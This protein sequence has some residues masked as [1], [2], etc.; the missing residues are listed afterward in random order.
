MA[1][2][3]RL[4]RQRLGLCLP[5]RADRPLWLHAASVG[6]LIAALPLLDALR[7]RHP[8]VPLIVTTTT[9]TGAR[10]ARTRLPADIVH[11]YLPVDWP[12]AVARFLRAVQ[13]RAALIMETELWPHL[14]L[15]AAARAIPLLIVNGRLSARSLHAGAWVKQLFR[16][17][18]G[19][20]R[21]VL[22]RSQ[23]DAEGYIA[24]GMAA[25]R[26]RVLGNIKFAAPPARQQAAPI[27]LGRPYVLAA[28]THADEEAQI[29]RLWLAND[30]GARFSRLLVIA[31]RHPAR[32]DAILKQ[33]QGLPATVAV[34]SRGERAGAD[35][36]IYLADTLG[37]LESFL[38]A[39]DIVFMGG[40]LAARG[41]HNILEAARLGR[42]LLFGPHMDNFQDEAALLL[43]GGAA[44]QVINSEELGECLR[45]WLS[46]PELAR[47]CGQRAADIMARQANVLAPY[48]Q[49][50][51]ELCA[52]EAATAVSPGRA[53]P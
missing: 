21:A 10:L 15:A 5:R 44:R 53:S 46:Q 28:S 12:G 47:D 48:L 33:L 51:S 11:V 25:E 43:E 8:S 35:T 16:L 1:R 30:F 52:L 50:V 13:P 7:R 39:A 14:F 18:L 23:Q 22:A 24:L 27:D 31:P 37:E 49:A 26:V 36:Q 3:P 9:P 6:E 34:R 40:S 45:E 41:G 20:V 4:F 17:S 38:A 19:G 42:P 32:R 29:A 2:D